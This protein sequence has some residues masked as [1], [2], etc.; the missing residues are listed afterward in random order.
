MNRVNGLRNPYIIGR[1]IRERSKFFGRESLFAFIEDNL[2]QGV[3]VILLHG[4]RRIGKSSVLQQVSNFIQSH[5]FIFVQFDLQ[6]QSNSSLSNIIGNL[7]IAITDQVTY[8]FDIDANNLKIPTQAQLEENINLFSQV[9]LPIIYEQINFR[10]IVLLFDEFDVANNEKIVEEQTFYSYIKKLSKEQDKLFIIPVIGRYFNDLPNLRSLF[11]DAPFEEIGLL[12]NTSAKQMI[13]KPAQG[14]LTYRNEAIQEIIQ[15]SAGHPCFTQVICSTLFEQARNEDK[16]SIEGTDVKLI[17]DKAIEKADAFMQSFWEILTIPERIIIST[18]AEAQQIAIEQGIKSPEEPLNLLSKKGIKQTE[19][20]SQAWERLIE[21]GYLYDAGRKVRVELIRRWLLQYHSLQDEIQSLKMQELQ[22]QKNETVEHLVNN[23]IAVANFWSEQGKHELAIQHYQ[24]ALAINPDNFNIKLF[25]AEQYFKVKDFENSLELY[26]QLYEADSSSYKERYLEVLSEYGHHL[27]IQ[28]VYTLSKEQYNRILKVDPKNKPAE[29]RLLEIKSIESRIIITPTLIKILA[30]LAILGTVGYGTYQISSDCPPGQEKEF[31][32][33]CKEDNSMI[34]SGDRT[35]FPE[36]KNSDRDRGIQA[37][38]QKKYPEAIKLFAQAVAANRNDPEVLIYYNNSLAR[39]K[40]NPITLAV[41]VPADNNTN[42]AQEMLRG[43]SQAQNEFN[44]KNGIKGRLLQ[45]KIAN[46]ASQPQQAKQVAA[47]LVTDKS[48]LGVIGHYSSDSTRAALEEYNRAD[49]AIIS[50]S[51]TSTQLQG[52]NFFRSLPSDAAGGKK[53]AEYAFQNLKLR[54]VVI[55]S[56]PDSSY[57]NS[58]REEF[59]NQFEKL[60][61]EV[62]RKPQINLADPSLDMSAEVY[63]TIYRD[64]DKAQAA[65][66]IPDALHK[67]VAVKIAKVNQ[68]VVERSQSQNRPRPGLKLLG[69]D[70]LYS[71]ETLD[72]G[73]N[74]VE[75]LTIVVPWFREA[76]EAQNF[77]QKAFK[78]WGKQVSWRTATSYDATQA[79][80]QALSDNSDR[81]TVIENLRKVNLSSSNTSGDPLQFNPEGERQTEPILV[82]IKGGTWVMLQQQ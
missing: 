55:F 39:D 79:F 37:F 65:V 29:Q 25:L 67:D 73:G 70:I 64:E 5:E 21:N 62:L 53:L 22:T 38:K 45:I 36:L 46:D 17:L 33:F 48:V 12:D 82:Q 6:H 61:G 7:A 43:V 76:P 35:F 26:K 19:Q 23:L 80:I 75:G 56:N 13:T 28:K 34:S 8:Q 30:V 11:K 50:P 18:V 69:G 31:A 47:K 59:K 44:S 27:F 78:Q 71:Q 1:P 57:S 40:G 24:Q 9:F 58:M 51:A 66:L 2:N 32:F 15:L 3:K 60:G 14:I 20:L 49:I 74:A 63:R 68:E 52:K 42:F 72:K 77:A 10:K 4:Q 41:V 54:R 16:W 81:T